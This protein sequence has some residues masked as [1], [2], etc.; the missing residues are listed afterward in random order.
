M[1]RVPTICIYCGCGCGLY[2]NVRD[3]KVNGV[4]PQRSHPLNSG[5]LCAKGWSIPELLRGYGRLT[6]PLIKEKGSFIKASWDKALGKVS[7]ELI[8][9]IKKY[10]PDSIGLFSSAKATNE[11]NYLMMK[12]ARAAIGT[13]NIDHCAR[14]CHASTVTGLV[15]TFGSGAMTN[16][17]NE[18]EDAKAILLTGSNPTEQHP[19]VGAKIRRAVEK[20]AKLI[21]VDPR[22]I[23]LTEFAHIHLRQKPGSDVA[24]INGMIRII[25]E[26]GWADDDF[27]RKRTENFENLALSV[28]SYTASMVEEITGIPGDLLYRAAEVYAKSGSGMIAYG[29]GITQ[30]VTGTDNVSALS[31]LAM[32]AGQAG[33]PSTGVNP[34]RGQ[35]NVQGACDMGALPNFLTGYQRIENREVREKFEKIWNVKLPESKGM[36]ITEMIDGAYSGKIKGLI[37]MGE[38]PLLSDPDINHVKKALEKLELLVVVELFMSETASIANVVLPSASFAEKD[39]TYTNTDRAI[40]RIR[41]AVLP[42]GESMADW[43]IICNLSERMGFE[44]GYEKPEEVMT[45][46]ASLTPIY[47]GVSYSRL[48]GE[49][50]LQWPCPDKSHPGTPYLYQKEFTRGKGFFTPVEYREPDEVTDSEFPFVLVTGRIYYHWHTGTMT[51]KVETLDREIPVGYVEINPADAAKIKIRDR[52][53]VKLISRRGELVTQALVTERVQEGVVFMP[54]HFK[55]AAANLLTNPAVDR[56]AKIPEFKVCSV[57]LEKV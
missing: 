1:I 23:P 21:V 26:Q 55:E 42:V 13:N 28:S 52:E 49:S 19:M 17:Q 56:E 31:N 10:G 30:H 16:S 43:E 40:Q 4:T 38:N 8:E 3:G 35:N 22:K 24:W 29:M 33:R 44:M 48:E 54:F 9:L 57:K 41:K 47:G 7:D 45:E 5:T 50:Y 20:G 6:S 39:G 46:I 14:L 37:V 18:F 12:F 53:S 27:I 11:E 15:K 51:R 32:V 25:I 36:T 2:L 34:L